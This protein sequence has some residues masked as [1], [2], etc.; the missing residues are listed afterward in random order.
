VHKLLIALAGIIVLLLIITFIKGQDVAATVNGQTITNKYIDEQYERIPTAYKTQ[1]T[2]DVV[3][4]QAINEELL[5]QEAAKK[6][7]SVTDEEVESAINASITQSGLDEES[8][9]Q[10]L[11]EQNLDMNDLRD[12]YRKQL[13]INKLIE[14]EVI[15]TIN[16]SD[17]VLRAYYEENKEQFKKGEEVTASHILILTDDRSDEEAKALIDDIAAQATP[18]NFAELAKKYSEGP[19]APRGGDL[20]TFGRGVMVQPFEDVAFSTPVGTISEPVRTQFGWHIIYVR[21]KNPGGELSFEEVKDQIKAQLLEQQAQQLVVSY[22]DQLK[23]NAD[24]EIK[25]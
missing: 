19:S 5:L 11:A 10:R 21:D 25:D 15:S 9:R 4:Q 1:I 18:E 20:G 14:Q 8:F 12:L 24:I 2:R 22:L 6:G 3:L 23:A 17:D 7:I 16:I 13:T